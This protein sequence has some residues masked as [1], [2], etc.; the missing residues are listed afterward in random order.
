MKRYRC[1][2]CGYE[3]TGDEPPEVCP[4]CGASKDAFEEIDDEE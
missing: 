2:V 1:S 4:V 3:H